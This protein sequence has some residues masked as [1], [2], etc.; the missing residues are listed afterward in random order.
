MEPYWLCGKLA[1]HRGLLGDGCVY[2]EDGRIAR[3]SKAPRAGERLRDYSGKGVLVAPGFIDI[4]VHLRGLQQSYK[5]T[6]ETG[7]WAAARAGIT[8]VIDMPNTIPRASTP[9][10]VER[11]LD[12]LSK[13]PVD[14]SIFAGVPD[15]CDLELMSSMPIAGYKIYPSDLP[16]QKTVELL[17]RWRGLVVVH[18]ELPE[19]EGVVE[20]KIRPRGLLRGCW[21]ETASL[22]LVA[23]V[24]PVSRL[25]VTHASCPST[26]KLA[27]SLGYTV[28]VTPHHLMYDYHEGDGCMYKVNPP[29]RGPIERTILQQMLL[30]GVI[31]AVASDHAP[32]AS[33][34]KSDPL[35]CSPGIPWL[36]VWPWILHR[37]VSAG[38]LSLGEFHRLASRGPAQILGLNDYG[39]LEPGARA[40]LVIYDPSERSRFGGPRHSK[41]RHYPSLMG[42]TSGKP[43]EVIV[44][45]ETVYHMD[46]PVHARPGVNP[47]TSRRPLGLA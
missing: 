32:H 7:G 25:H 27:K 41:A 2:I 18:P 10:V 12:A 47:F 34:E 31:D 17:R 6:E 15:P 39:S 43:V 45:G 40:N 9:E 26:V 20:E 42:E 30:E 36:E 1:D 44:G 13:A 22:D 35:Y 37:L 14:H 29:I 38:A 28:D 23:A 5:E 11:K 21:M 46:E 24:S 33:W 19:A 16:E 4:H 3:V 8:L